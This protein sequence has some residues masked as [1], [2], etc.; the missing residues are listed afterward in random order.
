MIRERIVQQSE[1]E[2][3]SMRDECGE[4]GRNGGM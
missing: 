2:R 1:G 3:I 4:G